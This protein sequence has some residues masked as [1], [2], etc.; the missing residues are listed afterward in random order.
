MQSV[1][2]FGQAEEIVTP[3]SPYDG[4]WEKSGRSLNT[5]AVLGL[6]GIGVLYFNA[7]IILTVIG[8]LFT[9]LAG[10]APPV[11]GDFMER[12]ASTVKL[13]ATPIRLAV[14]VSQYVFMLLPVWWLVKRWHT[15]NVRGYTR[16][17]GCS[18]V[19]ILLAVIGTVAV[20]PAGTYIANELM[21]WMNTSDA[22]SKIAAEIFTAHSFPEFVWLVFV[23]GLTPAI[24]E[25]FFF[26]GYVQRTF[27]RT[28]GEKSLWLIGV[29]FGLFHMQPLGL[30]TLS[31][32]GILFGY[33]Y[34]RSQSLLPSMA[35]HFTNNF[36]AILFLYL[37]P[38]VGD[39]NL[40][41]DDQ[42]PLSWVIVTLP[43]AVVVL[44]LYHKLT[45]TKFM[46]AHV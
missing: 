43:I 31:M 12:L 3:A 21:R 9:A 16:W 36:L 19:E 29:I 8:I 26:R 24:C 11:S 1:E 34:Y 4:A 46:N 42:I 40:A 44:F 2:E 37:T 5:A 14:V 35:A 30:I 38:Q 18:A 20:L 13:Y 41:S 27:E 22:L 23:V 7:Q 17:R 10:G 25:E 32:L 15:Q 28:L 6:L 39:V 33:F 45:K